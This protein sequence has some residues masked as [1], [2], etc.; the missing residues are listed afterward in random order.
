MAKYEQMRDRLPSLYRPQPG[1]DGLM[2]RFLQTV[3][4]LLEQV[5]LEAAAVL[6]AHWFEYADLALY[7]GFFQRRRQLQGDP[8]PPPGDPAL[9]AFPYLDD[10]AYLSAL[11]GLSPWQEPN[12]ETVEAFRLRV[13][14]TL[15]LYRDGLGTIEALRRMVELQLPVDLGAAP[16]RRDRPFWLEEGVPGAPTLAPAIPRGLPTDTVGPLMRWSH[17]H[18]GLRSVC[19]TLYI[20]GVAPQAGHIDATASPLIERYGGPGRPLGIAYLGALEAGETLR[21]QPAVTSWLGIASGLQQARSTT[22]PTASGPWAAVEDGPVGAVVAIAQSEDAA[23]WVAVNGPEGEGDDGGG[24]GGQL[25]RYDGR[26]WDEALTDL[27]AIHCLD[28][29]GQDLLIGTEEGLVRVPLFPP[30]GDELTPIALSSVAV[31]ALARLE[32]QLWLGTATGAFTLNGDGSLAPTDLQGVAVYALHSDGGDESDGARFFGTGWGL[33]HQQPRL[34]TWYRY[35][36]QVRTEQQSEWEAFRPPAAPPAADEA[37][38]P[39]VRA[40]ARSRDGSLWLGTDQG[41][42]RYLARPVRGFTSETILQAFPDLS[43]G[44]VHSLTIDSR[45]LLWIGCDRG[46]LRYDGHRLWQHQGD[47][48]QSLG[49]ADQI[50]GGDGGGDGPSGRDP[51]PRD[52]WRYSGADWERFTALPFSLELRTTEEAAVQAVAWTDGAIAALGQWDG[53]QFTPDPAAADPTPQLRMRYKPRPTEIRDGGLVAVPRLPVGDSTWRYLR[54]EG[55]SPVETESRPI[56]TSEGRLL[57]DNPNA[58][59]PESGRFDLEPPPPS[60]FDA[61]LFAFLPAARVWLSWQ[62]HQPASVLVRLQRRQA[63]EAIDPI[64]LDRVWAGLEQVR[65]AGVQVQLAL[66]DDLLRGD[67]ST[68]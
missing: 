67:L 26:T 61:S 20:Q 24:G 9:V 56:W 57:G 6:Q 33:L 14:R 46:L 13:R 58:I 62:P 44:R 23:L 60:H 22:D 10:L 18:R 27:A 41:L 63:G 66:G 8:P 40:I 36:G 1:D 15:A 65:P 64:I 34:G 29:N 30:A 39:T 17:T 25:W 12:P 49:R 51:I 2:A 38:L 43:E 47:R 37:F 48:W 32:G 53:T 45:G 59:D 11:V 4:R 42:A 3:G 35:R 54:V 68:G 55:E 21:I 19:P 28:L 7:D 31:Y 16:A 52:A 50:Y 5:D